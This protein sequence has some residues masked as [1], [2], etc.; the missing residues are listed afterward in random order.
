MD[1]NIHVTWICLQ[2]MPK[3]I[4]NDKDYITQQH[5]KVQRYFL[6]KSRMFRLITTKK[7]TSDQLRQAYQI[8]ITELSP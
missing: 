5:E 6:D 7:L 2:K 4:C 3:K 8:S 1:V